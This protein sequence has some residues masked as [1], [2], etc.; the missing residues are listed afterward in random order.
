MV[1]KLSLPTLGLCST[2]TREG[3]P[4]PRRL[5]AERGKYC[6]SAIRSGCKCLEVRW[7]WPL[8]GMDLQVGRCF[9]K[10]WEKQRQ[11]TTDPLLL[12]SY[13]HMYAVSRG[14][15]HL[16]RV[17]PTNPLAIPSNEPFVM[18]GDFNSC[19]GSGMTRDE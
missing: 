16:L 17:P 14:K 5:Q 13:L 10:G 1:W 11:L 7:W 2:N 6:H 18:L 15:E 3:S 19:V 9:S 4:W 12:C 8:E